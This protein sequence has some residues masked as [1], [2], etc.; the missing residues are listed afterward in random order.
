MVVTR[1]LQLRTKGHCD[2]IDITEQ[3]MGEL[4]HSG[5]QDGIASLFV[6]GST[7][8]LT[9]IEYE[10]GLVEDFCAFWQ[11][12]A[13]EGIPYGHDLRWDDNNGHSHVRA[14]ALG[15]SLTIP[16]SGGRPTLGRWQQVILVDFDNRPR[17]RE[18]VLQVIGE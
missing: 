6:V 2:I 5:L 16:F 4:A 7:A 13:P 12:V 11:R 17:S 10:P 9:T 15:P 1:R 14:S 8:G 3:L 18:I